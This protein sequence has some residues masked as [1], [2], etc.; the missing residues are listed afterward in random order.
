MP[1]RLTPLLMG[2]MAP[3][4]SEDA[5]QCGYYKHTMAHVLAALRANR[6]LLLDALDVFVQEPILNWDAFINKIALRRRRGAPDP[7][8]AAPRPQ[9]VT[10]ASDRAARRWFPQEKLAVV[11]SKLGLGNPGRITAAE[12]ERSVQAANPT[13][14][15]KMVAVAAGDPATDKRA[16]LGTTCSSVFVC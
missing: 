10:A 9:P 11:R 6:A 5:R 3:G 13:L 16:R 8:A 15:R 4:A 14:C 1:F 12:L 2:V 7:A